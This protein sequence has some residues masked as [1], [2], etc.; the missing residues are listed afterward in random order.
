M[1]TLLAGNFGLALPALVTAMLLWDESADICSLEFFASAISNK[2]SPRVCARGGD[3]D[4]V[5]GLPRPLNSSDSELAGRDSFARRRERAHGGKR[6]FSISEFPART[7]SPQLPS[8]CMLVTAGSLS[9][10]SQIS[11]DRRVRRRCASIPASQPMPGT[12][13]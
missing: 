3:Y 6:F 12:S 9:G 2:R 1:G 13:Y 10:Y 11:D 4:E 7:I 8:G 5:S